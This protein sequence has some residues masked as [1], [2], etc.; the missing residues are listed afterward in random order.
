[1]SNYSDRCATSHLTDMLPPQQSNTVP[2]ETPIFINTLSYLAMSIAI[3]LIILLQMSKNTTQTQ[4]IL[5][6]LV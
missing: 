6:R 3:S 2:T 4:I 1:M 5:C